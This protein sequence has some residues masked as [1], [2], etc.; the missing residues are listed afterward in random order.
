M[1]R[2]KILVADDEEGIRRLMHEALAPGAD[3]VLARD[4]TEALAAAQEATPDLILLDL[5]MPGL[6]GLTVLGKLKTIPATRQIPVVIVSAHGE[7][8]LLLEGQRGGAVDH[9]IKPFQL[10][11]LRRVVQRQLAFLGED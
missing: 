10:D 9:L 7:S 2:P 11:E 8:E 1:K 4:G 6:D 3:V 5:R